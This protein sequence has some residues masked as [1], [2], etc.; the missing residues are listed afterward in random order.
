MAGLIL[1]TFYIGGPCSTVPVLHYNNIHKLKVTI[2][3]GMHQN[4]YD[5]H[6]FNNLVD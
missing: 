6:T 3:K 1:I 2:T 4:Y 5:I